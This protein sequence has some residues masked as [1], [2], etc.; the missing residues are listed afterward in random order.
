[1][2]GFGK[3]YYQNGKVAYEG[4]WE[5]NQYNG[6]GRVYNEDPFSFASEYNYKDLS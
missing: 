1:M 2:H 6:Q 4:H 5:N 3:L